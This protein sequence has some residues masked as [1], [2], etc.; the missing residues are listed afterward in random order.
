MEK[1]VV[2]NGEEVPRFISGQQAGYNPESQKWHDV[3]GRFAKR[4]EALRTPNEWGRYIKTPSMS[5][6]SDMAEKLEAMIGGMDVT[7]LR[8]AENMTDPMPSAMLSMMRLAEFYCMEGDVFQTI[9][10]PLDIALKPLEFQSSDSGYQ[11][12]LEEL[13]SEEHLDMYQN[14]YYIW[15][16][17]GQYG[18]AFPLT[19]FDE[20]NPQD[21]RI[22]LIPPKNVRVGRSFSMGG[23]IGIM[24]PS[25]EGWTQ[26][27]LETAFPPMV[28]NRYVADWNE[29]IAQGNDIIIPPADCYP[30]REKSLPFQRYAIPPV[31]RASR[32]LS[33][34]RIF[35]EMRRA[36][37][38]GFKNQLWFFRYGDP[39][40]E[41]MP[42][43]EEIQFLADQVEGMYG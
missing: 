16:C 22:V 26:Q 42:L 7:S 6:V 20:D 32:A 17:S 37:V 29:S 19:V 2:L 12:E 28:Y 27:L 5:P 31:Y 40:G 38:E 33:T 10:V 9:E 8:A 43:P 39:K 13:Y 4:E 34:R 36:T 41:N 18:Q 21:S 14:M 30:V 15:L 35:E 11:R 25:S 24:S 3:H 1:T 23:N